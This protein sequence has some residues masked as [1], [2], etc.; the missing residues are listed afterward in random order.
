MRS[1]R[2]IQR[3]AMLDVLESKTATPSERITAFKLLEKM[4]RKR[5]S[6]PSKPRTLS[7][8]SVFS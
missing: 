5:S 4:K 2:K 1:R 7:I 3:N 6:K 8:E